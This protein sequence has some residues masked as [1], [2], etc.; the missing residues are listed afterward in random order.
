MAVD[1]ATRLLEPTNRLGH[2]LQAGL[3]VNIRTARAYTSP[4][5]RSKKPSMCR[6]AEPKEETYLT[7][8]R[9]I[10]RSRNAEVS[11]SAAVL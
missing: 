6:L 3:S 1:A 2:K 7:R 11:N 5:K 9:R 8:Q 4:M 10:R